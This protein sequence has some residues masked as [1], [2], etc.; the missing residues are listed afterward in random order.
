MTAQ[1]REIVLLITENLNIIADLAK[2]Y[3]NLLKIIID[4]DESTKTNSKRNKRRTGSSKI[5]NEN[6]N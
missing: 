3:S 4:H 6:N 5:A 1:N 2:K